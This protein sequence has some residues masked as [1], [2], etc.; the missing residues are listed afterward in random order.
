MCD[1]SLM[2]LPN[3]LAVRGEDLIVHRF[4]HGTLGLASAAELEVLPAMTHENKKSGFLARL[5]RFLYPPVPQQCTAVC[6][7]PGAHLLL[8]DIPKDVQGRF[9]L[10][11]DTQEVV[12]T[13]IGTSGFRDAI[14]FPNGAELLLQRLRAGQRVCVLALSSEEYYRDEL[15]ERISTFTN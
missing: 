5:M 10:E 1:Y 8:K 12:F 3:R 9:N 6:I 15:A 4:E 11:N 7:P 2:S 13:Q 14:R